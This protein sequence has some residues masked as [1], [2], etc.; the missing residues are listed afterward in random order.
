MF[1]SGGPGSKPMALNLGLDDEDFSDDDDQ[2]PPP[3]LKQAAPPQKPKGS[4]PNHRP[5]VGGFAAAAYEAARD[6]ANKK[7][8][9]RR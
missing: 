9:V 3:Q 6:A 8:Q 2:G 1:P 7:Q 4:G 5:Y